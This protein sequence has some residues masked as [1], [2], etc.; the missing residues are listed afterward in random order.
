MILHGAEGN[1][2][3]QL[4]QGLTIKDF[5]V[6]KNGFKDALTLLKTNENFTLNAANRIYHSTDSVLGQSYIQSTKEY[7]LAEPVG[8]DFGQSEEARVAINTWVE[9][10][11]KNKI[12][13]LI[14]KGSITGLTKLVLV[15]AIYFKGDWD[16]KFDKAKT[17]KREFHVSSEKNS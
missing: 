9:E 15:N 7:F 14:A 13:D 8:T 17:K 2:A 16:I 3:S 4:K 12:Q 10:Q 6:V 5:D 1:T 11:T